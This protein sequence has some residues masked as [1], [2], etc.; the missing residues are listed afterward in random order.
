MDSGKKAMDALQ[1]QFDPY[2]QLG[3]EEALA[4]ATNI[5]NAGGEANILERST[6]KGFLGAETVVTLIAVSSA[7]AAVLSVISAFLY[8]VFRA[9]VVLDLSGTTPK[10][11]KASALPRGTTL[12]LYADGRQ[13]LHEATSRKS[14]GELMQAAI[15][16]SK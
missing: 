2:D 6:P 16:S 9:G 8:D 14:I 11:S 10:I 7:S 4:L 5:G 15:R 3:E 1:I 13:E 12:I